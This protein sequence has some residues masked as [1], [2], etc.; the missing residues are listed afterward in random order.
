[1]VSLL[2]LLDLETIILSI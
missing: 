1:M 2:I